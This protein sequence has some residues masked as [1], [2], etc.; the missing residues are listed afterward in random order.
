MDVVESPA[1]QADRPTADTQTPVFGLILFGG[2]LSGALN[3]DVRLANEL[4]DRGFAVHVWWVMDRPDQSPLRKSI[5]QRMLFNG[6]RYRIRGGN[7]IFE[8]FGRAF[9]ALYGPQAK[10]TYTIQKR[11]Y[12]AQALMGNLFRSVVDGVEGD[13]II[14]RRLARGLRET[15]VTHMLPMLAMLCPYVEAAR[16]QV[17]HHVHYLVTFQGYE[18][19]VNYARRAKLEQELYGRL[20][21]TTERSDFTAIAVSDDYRQRVIDDIGVPG[22]MLA[23]IPPGVPVLKPMDRDAAKQCLVEELRR[24][25]YDPS[26]PLV[27]YLGRQDTEKGID[28]LLYAGRLLRQRG[29]E[30]QLAVCGP[31]LFGAHYSKVMRQLAVDLQQ[32]VIWAKHISDEARHALFSASRCFVYPS[33]HR[34][35][36]GMAPVEA[37]G[38][39]AP[40]VVPDYGGVANTIHAPGRC[41]GLRFRAWDSGDLADQIDRLLT[42]DDLYEKLRADGVAVAEHYSVANLA[43]RILKHMNLPTHPDERRHTTCY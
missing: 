43:D 30:F 21:E 16:R 10:R 2:G 37:M 1:D 41:A 25:H 38:S 14:L 22:D 17:D 31:T 29:R 39:G 15:G 8:W 3:R 34:E 26:L 12:L 5:T 32:P 11:P 18:L 27:S 24:Y 7:R 40:A 36:F 19:Y 35:P 42:D 4:A 6:Y 9:C 23:A 33:I 20:R 13:S 28:L